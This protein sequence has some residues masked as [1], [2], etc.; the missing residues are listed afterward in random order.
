VHDPQATFYSTSAAEPREPG[1]LDAE[2]WVRNQRDTVHFHDAI[3]AALVDGHRLFI[4]CGPHPLAVRP[5]TDTALHHDVRDTLAVGSLRRDVDDQEAFM[6]NLATVHCGGYA[7]DWQTR[8]GDGPLAEVPGTAWRRLSL[9]AKEKPYQLVAP[10]LPAAS[11]HPLLGGH[12][13]DPEAPGRHLWQTPIS[14]HRLSWLGDHQVADVAVM[15]GTGL[16]EMMLAAAAEVFDTTHLSLSELSIDAPLLLEP[17]PLVTTRLQSNGRVATAEVLSIQGDAHIVHARAK[18]QALLPHQRPRPV[19]PATLTTPQW[20]DLVPQELYAHV[21]KRHNVIHGPSFAAI[22]RIQLHPEQNHAVSSV[23]IA[24][25]ARVSAWTMVLHPALADQLVQTAVGAWIIPHAT[26]PGPVVVGGAEEIR[27]YGPTAH[28]RLVRVELDHADDLACTASGQLIALDGTVVAEVRGLRVVNVTP[29]Q[30]RFNARLAHLE[31]V[32]EPA[33]KSDDAMRYASWLVIAPE[34]TP[35]AQRLGGLLDDGSA[36]CRLLTHGLATALT[37]RR[38]DD[39]LEAAASQAP[40]TAV[41]VAVGAHSGQVDRAAAACE[42]LKRAVTII[43]RSAARED[44]PRLWLVFRGDEG[45]LTAAGLRGLWRAAAFEHP[46]LVPSIIDISGGTPLEAVLADLLARDQPITEIA[47]WHGTRHLARVRPGSGAT[48]SKPRQQPVR[49]DAAYLVTGGLGGLGL[50]TARWL[51]EQGVRRAVVCGRSA[52]TEHVAQELDHLRATTQADISVVLGDIADPTV[53]Q[54]VLHTATDGDLPLRGV[55]HA[56]GVVEDA[57][58]ANLDDQLIDRVWRGKAEGA[59]ALHQATL[60]HDLDF[61]VVYSSVAALL[62]S[63]GQAAYASANAFL[64]D[65][66][67]RRL[68]H[69]LPATGIHWGAWSQVGRGQHLAEQG[70][71]TISPSDGIGA[72]ERILTGGHRQIAYSPIDAARW[73]AAYPA[74]ADST[75]L[76]DLLTGAPAQSSGPSPVLSE[77]LEAQTKAQRQN[78]LESHV[79]DCMRTVM[80]GTTRHIAPDTSLVMLGADSLAAVQLQQQLQNTLKI[81]IKPGVIWVKPS[82][83]GLAEWIGQH[84]GFFRSEEK[85]GPDAVPGVHDHAAA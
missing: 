12:V 7:V 38:L 30:E 35:W 29:A 10:H 75:L 26:S 32:P 64:D 85:T 69:G 79:I 84:M 73:T 82:A 1:P 53:L 39:A 68:G 66:V 59:W 2:Y 48:A 28:A 31:W 36:G 50:V 9:D 45:P 47:W 33:P 77:L 67:S 80:G 58:L 70:Q 57:T 46:E 20:R 6:A 63:P 74:L 52:P 60:A 42:E 81:T 27:V 11:E 34:D 18:V 44:P 41:V 78:I 40:R 72:L 17:E 5:I 16:A 49:P 25:S 22:E 3:A 83:A 62:G 65:L 55:L 24:D 21:R 51:A 13:H 61:F 37:P 76:H 15:P 43:Q 71:V 19:D 54:H 23:R 14:P 4:E 56:A 8:Y